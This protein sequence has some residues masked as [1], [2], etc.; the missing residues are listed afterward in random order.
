MWRSRSSEEV[1]GKI[2]SEMLPFLGSYADILMEGNLAAF[3][4]NV[5]NFRRFCG[6]IVPKLNYY[7]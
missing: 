1:S 7:F 4:L 2:A 3:F 6:E 5:I